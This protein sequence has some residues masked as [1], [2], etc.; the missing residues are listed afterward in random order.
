MGCGF[1]KGKR[2]VWKHNTDEGTVFECIHT[3]VRVHWDDGMRVTY[4][5]EEATKN[6]LVKE[7]QKA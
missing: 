1:K 3:H 6:I 4:S 7:T 5:I 2:V